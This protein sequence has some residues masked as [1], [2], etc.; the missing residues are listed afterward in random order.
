MKSMI[1][2]PMD[3]SQVKISHVIKHTGTPTGPFLSRQKKKKGAD[4][5]KSIASF[6]DGSAKK[7]RGRA[8]EGLGQL[9]DS[10]VQRYLSFSFYFLCSSKTS[11]SRARISRKVPYPQTDSGLN[12]KGGDGKFAH[13][14]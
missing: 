1:I 10:A 2:L 12:C 11:E 13:L 6:R 9:M 7:I 5:K 8:K 4:S 14:I 3:S